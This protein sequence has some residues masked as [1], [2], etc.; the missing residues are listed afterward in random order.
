MLN[1]FSIF[2]CIIEVITFLVSLYTVWNA[3]AQILSLWQ[4]RGKATQ[5]IWLNVLVV[6][7]GL[8]SVGTNHV[9]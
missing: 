9:S 5:F 2:A 4:S 6:C 3:R 1:G 8:L 7:F